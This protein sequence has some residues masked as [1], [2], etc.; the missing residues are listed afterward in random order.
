M[1]FVWLPNYVSDELEPP[2]RHGLAVN[3]GSM[4]FFLL[5]LLM[6]GHLSDIYGF[7][8]VMKYGCLALFF[9]CLPGYVF[10]KAFPGK[11]WPMAIFQLL[12]A[13][14]Y[15]SVGGPLQIFMISAVEDVSLRYSVIGIGYNVSQALFGGTAPAIGEALASLHIVLVGVYVGGMSLIAGALLHWKEKDK[16]H[17]RLRETR[18]Q[19]KTRERLLF[20]DISARKSN[21]HTL[22]SQAGIFKGYDNLV[23][24]E[25]PL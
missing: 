11:G 17:V 22:S 19:N 12:F 15:G 14:G 23:E 9:I 16:R 10:I 7:T 20:F 5:C 24:E 3:S 21:G 1:N 18:R 4:F 25:E 6:A 13:M 2:F 8:K